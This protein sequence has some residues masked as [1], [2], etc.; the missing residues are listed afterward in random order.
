MAVTAVALKRKVY[1]SPEELT[2]VHRAKKGDQDAFT[3]L[4]N[5]HYNRLRVVINRMIRD[6]SE[7]EWRANIALT[8]AW[9]SLNEFHEES[10]FSTWITRFAINEALMY[11][12]HLKTQRQS[13]T[14]SLEE[15]TAG[16]RNTNRGFATRDLNLEGIADRE[17]LERAINR[18][19]AD[20]REILRMRFWEGLSV[21]DIRKRLGVPPRRMSAVKTRLLRGRKMLQ[22][23][24][25]KASTAKLDVFAELSV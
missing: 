15:I 4:Y 10:K 13:Q 18:V 6:E 25:E 20:Y 1:D 2:L 22:E 5:H 3:A 8:K 16:N 7:A 12:R 11:M 17:V 14:C 23:Q 21:D 9:E 24:V 19:P